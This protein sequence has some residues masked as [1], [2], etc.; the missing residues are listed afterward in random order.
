MPPALIFYTL[1]GSSFIKSVGY[2]AQKSRLIVTIQG[3]G[4]DI[5][6]PYEYHDVPL[7]TMTDF[8]AAKSKGK[9][10]NKFIKGKYPQNSEILLQEK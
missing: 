4:E 8:I 7:Q 2:Y 9:Y 1:V 6:I 5:P 10:Y 3:K